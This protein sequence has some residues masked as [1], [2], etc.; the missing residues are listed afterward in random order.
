MAIVETAP[1]GM[2]LVG[3]NAADLSGLDPL[4]PAATSPKHEEEMLDLGEEK[5]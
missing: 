3:V 5:W 1:L 2:T 4:R